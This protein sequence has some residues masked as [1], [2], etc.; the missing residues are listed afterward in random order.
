GRA[1]DD[2]D[3]GRLAKGKLVKVRLNLSHAS[4]AAA[5][6]ACS[7]NDAQVAASDPSAAY[8]SLKAKKKAP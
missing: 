7:K 6:P 4:L 5:S 2:E 3:L 8:R 1:E